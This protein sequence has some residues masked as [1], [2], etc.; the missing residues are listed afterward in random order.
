MP[1]AYQ[2]CRIFAAKFYLQIFICITSLAVMSTQRGTRPAPGHRGMAWA[3]DGAAHVRLLAVTGITTVLC[4]RTYLALTGYPR[5]GGGS[6]HIAHA[7]WG[8]LLMLAAMASSLLFAGSR[9]RARTAVLGGIGLGLSADEVGKFLTQDEDYFFRPAAVIIYLLFAGLLAFAT[10]LARRRPGDPRTGLASAAQIAADGVFSGLTPCQMESAAALLAGHH[11]DDVGRAIR[12]LLD[13]APARERPPLAERLTM[14]LA[15]VRRRVAGS[16]GFIPI[17]IAGF[18][19]SHAAVATALILHAPA[20]GGDNGHGRP[21]WAAAAGAAT[22]ALAASLALAG[23]VRWRRDP[24]GGRRWLHTAVLA[25]LLVT[26]VFAFY[27]IQFAAVAG[28]PA[29]LAVLAVCGRCGTELAGTGLGLTAPARL[30]ALFCRTPRGDCHPIRE[31]RIHGG[32][33]SFGYRPVVSDEE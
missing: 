32:A 10:L 16:R 14:W 24:R 31:P 5:L 30:R 29:D 21:H 3:P 13:V 23:A 11:D 19:A 6:L 12:Q 9:A 22:A 4:T 26:Q 18:I 8:V 33:L 17:L 28:L 25:D 7:L 2:V 27:A 1:E 20:V 15:A